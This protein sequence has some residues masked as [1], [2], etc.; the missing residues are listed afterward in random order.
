MSD[1][2]SFSD[3]LLQLMTG[4]PEGA[5]NAAVDS[6]GMSSLQ[7]RIE[8]LRFAAQHGVADSWLNLGVLLADSGDADGAEDAWRRSADAG[9]QKGAFMLAQLLEGQGRDDEALGMFLR[10]R[11]V[12]GSSL[13]A[14][15]IH[16]RR[17]EVDEAERLL[18]DSACSEAESA[19]ECVLRAEDGDR[20]RDIALLEHH[21]GHGAADV[22]IP[23]AT[24][25]E[26]VGRTADAEHALRRAL[27][28]GEANARLNLGILLYEHDRVD[29]GLQL[30]Q[31]ASA[32]GDSAASRWLEKIARP[33]R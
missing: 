16:E 3:S 5:F 27:A 18:A 23:L 1:S 32:L 22:L 28:A 20:A 26:R 33:G 8:L 10:A 17:G 4:D 2:A 12:D 29:E 15:R 6:E 13:R 31:E 19:V 11:P 7:L 9:D 24:L 30:A 25:Y 21:L 14:A